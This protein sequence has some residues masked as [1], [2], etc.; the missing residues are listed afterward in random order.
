M[1]QDLDKINI[2]KVIL[3]HI[4]E[5]YPDLSMKVRDTAKYITENRINLGSRI[6]ELE[7]CEA[8]EVEN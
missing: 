4:T 7:K 8:E 2:I 5:T 1:D 3:N 6:D